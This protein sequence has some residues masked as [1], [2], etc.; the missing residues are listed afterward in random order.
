MTT[1]IDLKKYKS[2]QV[3]S[4]AWISDN[5]NL[6]ALSYALRHPE[7]WPEG[8]VWDYRD[9]KTCAIGLASKLWNHLNWPADQSALN[10]ETARHFAMSY[11]QANRIFWNLGRMTR[12][13]IYLLWN[14]EYFDRSDVTPDDVADA[15]DRYLIE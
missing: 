11:K 6:T 8:F 13:R 1:Q 14:Q 10:T 2:A 5:P 7:T 15:I 3:Q 9:C 4:L 12:K